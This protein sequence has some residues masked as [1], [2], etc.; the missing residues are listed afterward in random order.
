MLEILSRF[1]FN[2][3][4]RKNAQEISNETNIPKRTVARKL[5]EAAEE[6]LLKF[7]E[8]GR[9]KHYY[10]DLDD[11]LS[12]YLL[13]FLEDYKAMKFYKENPKLAEYL[14]SF[15]VDK[16]IFG[17]YAKEN[18]GNDL[19]VV[20]LT[21]KELDTDFAPVLIHSQNATLKEFKKR[22]KNKEALALEIADNHITIGKTQ[23]I[24][25]TFIEVYNG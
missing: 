12:F 17:S 13:I 15:K 6:S 14:E 19:D 2:Y 1:T 8:T 25:K 24:V 21:S 18:K 7:T 23:E 20:F 22:L 3:S 11:V 4:K 5:K 10:I 16:I 9:N